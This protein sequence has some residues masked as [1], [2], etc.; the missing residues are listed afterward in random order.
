MIGILGFVVSLVA[1][2]F[3]VIGLIPFLGWLNWLTTLP[4]SIVGAALS[5]VG[6]VRHRNHIAVAGLAISIVVF[7]IAV[8][9]LIIGCGII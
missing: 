9:R 3:M 8:G 7:F 4:L 6:L 1:A 5:A 2:G